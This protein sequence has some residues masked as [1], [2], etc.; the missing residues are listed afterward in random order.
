[1]GVAGGFDGGALSGG[2]ASGAGAGGDTGGIEHDT[3]T[4]RIAAT[5]SAHHPD[6][7]ARTMWLILLE[8]LGALLL[9]AFI[10]WWT[11]FSGRRRGEPPGSEHDERGEP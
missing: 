3:S 4:P 7:E 10:V 11:M 2:A 5:A 1:M 9:L 8:A 6:I